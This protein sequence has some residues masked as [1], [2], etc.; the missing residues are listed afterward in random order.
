MRNTL[1]N[2]ALL[3]GICAV[4]LGLMATSAEAAVA[5]RLTIDDTGT[6]GLDYDSGIVA[7]TAVGCTGAVCTA[8]GFN[9]QNVVGN[10]SGTSNAP[11]TASI[12]L[13]NL[14]AAHITHTTGTGQLV[15]TVTGFDFSL[16]VGFNM[17][18]V[19]TASA[20]IQVA[21]GFSDASQGFADPTNSGALSNGSAIVTLNQ[22]AGSSS[23]SM[24]NN[25]LPSSWLRTQPLYSLTSRA[26]INL[27]SGE[28]VSLGQASQATAT[29]VPEPASLLLLGS[30]LL[31]AGR[32]LRRRKT[33]KA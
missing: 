17:D 11:G 7:G 26:I 24:S 15:I 10:A 21:T 29:A 14:Q 3:A 8:G 16:P 18:L 22:P 5:I 9:F 20:T 6:A 12:A 25:S 23:T 1:M 2:K 28:I 19:D 31:V 27:T 13:L 32:K 30:G 4:T 33:A